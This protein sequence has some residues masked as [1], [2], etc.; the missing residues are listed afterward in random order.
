MSK[1]FQSQLN[2]KMECVEE[3]KNVE[4]KK[5]DLKQ[6]EKQFDYICQ[7]PRIFI[8]D[9]FFDRRNVIDLNVE[10]I[11]FEQ[12]KKCIDLKNQDTNE[13]KKNS[14]SK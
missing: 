14:V 11:L 10:K 9:F 4:E 5:S 6:I 13:S 3:F 2:T 1:I 8:T 12:S 7:M